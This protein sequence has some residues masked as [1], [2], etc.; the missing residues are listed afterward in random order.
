MK[1]PSKASYTV[2]VDGWIAG[3]YHRAGTPL[4][5]TQG[6]AAYPELEGKIIP[7][8]PRLPTRPASGR[9]RRGKA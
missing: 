6:E 3:E 8:A 9:K 4:M 7:G 2:L 1:T 5:L